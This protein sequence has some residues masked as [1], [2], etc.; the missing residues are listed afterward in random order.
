MA[1]DLYKN[2]LFHDGGRQDY[3]LKAYSLEL[4]KRN[5]LWEIYLR[6]RL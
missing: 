1:N 2:E 5:L 4:P 3:F 6:Q